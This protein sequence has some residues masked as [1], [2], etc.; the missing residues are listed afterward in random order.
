VS[1]NHSSRNPFKSSLTLA[2][3][4]IVFGDIG[5][6]PLYAVREAF[7]GAHGMPAT[8]ENILGVL[9]LILWSLII[10]ISIK[11][12]LFVLRADNRGEGGVL[13]LAALAAPPRFVNKHLWSKILLYLG[14]FGSALLFGDGVITPAI[15]VLGAIE[16]LEVATP[17]FSSFVVPITLVILIFLFLYQKH[18][19]AKIGAVFGPVILIWFVALAAL[20][21][22]G[23]VTN[24]LVLGALNP[25]H[26]A[27]F[28]QINGSN[29]FLVLGAVFL[30]VT[31]GEALYA[32]M[33]H[34]GRTPI[35]RGWFFVAL[36]GLVLNYFGQGALLLRDPHAAVNPFY[37][38]APSWALYP[39]VVLATMAAV[40]ASQAL[41]SGV[42]SMVR[43]AMQLGYSPRVRIIHTSDE[44]IGQIYIPQANWVM[45][46]M[47]CWIVIEF[48]SSTAL[49]SAYGIAVST[50][51]VITTILACSVAYQWWR[52]TWIKTGAVLLIFLSVDVVFLAANFSKIADGGWVPL[53]M[54]IVVFTMMTTWRRGRQIL[55]ARLKEKSIPFNE[56]LKKIALNPPVKVSGAGVFM[57]GDPEGTPPALLHN[58]KHN[59]VLHERNILLTVLTED[60]PHIQQRDRVDVDK[61]S[62]SFYRVT[63]YY[64]FMETPEIH[65]ILDGCS[66]KELSLPIKD[67]TF[68]LGRETLIPTKR[69][70]M[71]IWRE[72]LFA[73]MSRNAER[74]TSYFNIPVDQ[75][76]EIGIQV[77]L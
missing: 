51:M 77:E 63:A 5:T 4:G 24:P 41:I 33:G 43:Q 29:G 12:L 38:L 8:T 55:M 58:L 20:G 57:T 72:Y 15:T 28:F 69:P 22:S 27:Y 74:A 42:F 52:W 16:G 61:L 53:L 75:V 49:A 17:F 37:Q 50:T 14:L 11:Y 66:I 39:L 32:D 71:A 9:S 73:F 19:T 13:A 40:I 25:L 46:L 6:S 2:A 1:N 36:P 56:F 68:F 31:G 44:E 23:I 45:L 64:G 30:V 67:I 3:L 60:V 47:T 35:Q 65:Q 26:A 76:V 48:G 62:E 59:H 10:V 34:F 21:V 54:G 18:G 70:G 7:H